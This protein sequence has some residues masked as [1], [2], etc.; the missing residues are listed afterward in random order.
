MAMVME[1]GISQ[2]QIQ[3][4]P[5]KVAM[6]QGITVHQTIRCISLFLNEIQK[7]VFL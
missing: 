6:A 3:M 1:E 2:S 5:G 7:D 4:V